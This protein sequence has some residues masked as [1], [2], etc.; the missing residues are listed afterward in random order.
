MT[1]D[2][3]TK[4][5][6]VSDIKFID[7]LNDLVE[8]VP[9][10]KGVKKYSLLLS[11]RSYY[12]VDDDLRTI[13]S[14][15]V[16]D[17]IIEIYFPGKKANTVS[18]QQ[19]KYK[20]K[21]FS[22]LKSSLNKNL[23][24][25]AEKGENP[26]GIIV[27]MSNAF[28]ISMKVELD[29]ASESGEQNLASELQEVLSNAGVELKGDM[30]EK[31]KEVVH[32][33]FISHQKGIE[34]IEEKRAAEK[35]NKQL[36]RK[37]KKLREESSFLKEDIK[38]LRESVSVKEQELE[39]LSK[40]QEVDQGIIKEIEEKIRSTLQ[41]DTEKHMK[42]LTEKDEE[43]AKHEKML[44][45]KENKVLQL[46]REMTEKE[47][48]LRENLKKEKE[49]L[50]NQFREEKKSLQKK[51]DDLVIERMEL[52]KKQNENLDERITMQD[53][54]DEELERLRKEKTEDEKVNQKE[55]KDLTKNM[56]SMMKDE[57][58]FHGER[59]YQRR[60][61]AKKEEN[62]QKMAAEQ[63]LASMEI[64]EAKT[65]LEKEKEEFR[66]E[67]KKKYDEEKEQL[68]K[69]M[70]EEFE[71]FKK[72]QKE[73]KKQK[74]E[75]IQKQKAIREKEKVLLE[76]VQKL[77][78]QRLSKQ[79]AELEKKEERLTQLQKK[80]EKEEKLLLV[81]KS[82]LLNEIK[83]GIGGKTSLLKLKNLV[84]QQEQMLAIKQKI[85]ETEDFAQQGIVE[86]IKNQRKADAEEVQAKKK[87]LRD[88]EIRLE[89]LREQLNQ[90]VENLAEN[91]NKAIDEMK[92]KY[93]NLIA[94]KEK[95]YEEKNLEWNNKITELNSKE[96]ELLKKQQEQ[97][98]KEKELTS[99]MDEK[100]E[101]LFKL[102]DKNI[103]Q[104]EKLIN[105]GKQLTQKA[106]ILEKNYSKNMSQVKAG[107]QQKLQLLEKKSAAVSDMESHLKEEQMVV[108]AKT[109][110]MVE[111]HMEL[112]KPTQEELDKK[113]S[114]LME[115]MT[116]LNQQ[117]DELQK[118]RNE[119]E[120]SREKILEKYKD[121]LE[122]IDGVIHERLQGH[123]EKLMESIRSGVIG[124]AS[125][126]FK[127][128]PTAG[129][130]QEERE[131]MT[132]E[133]TSIKGLEALAGTKAEDAVAKET[134]GGATKK[135][136]EMPSSGEGS[137]GD[138]GDEMELAAPPQFERLLT[139]DYSLSI[140]VPAG[141]FLMGCD[142]IP[143]S[144]PRHKV[145]IERFFRISKYPITIIQFLQFVKE[146]GHFTS[147]EK[148][149]VCGVT[150]GGGDQVKRD[151]N[152]K[153]VE[154][155]VRE[156]VTIDNE[157]ASW[158][159]PFGLE[160]IFEQ[161]FNHPVTMITWWD[162]MAYCDWLS[163][164]AGV[165]CRLPTEKEWEY[166][167][168]NRG[169]LKPGEFYWGHEERVEQHC[170][171]QNSFFGDTTPVDKFLENKT[172]DGVRDMLGNVWEWTLDAYYDYS[173]S[174]DRDDDKQEYKVVRG[175]SYALDKEKINTFI[176]RPYKKMYASSCI[177]FRVVSEE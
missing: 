1:K 111:E 86:E 65:N 34:K 12:K 33:E 19:I 112:S 77:V 172:I 176:R 14:I 8:K 127:G 162:C 141:E 140:T 9:H 2:D 121:K 116:G 139:Q 73:I 85:R 5:E 76:V 35:A 107:Y 133:S 55:W 53:S 60:G 78:N 156:P 16:E 94:R 51:V 49:T 164:K 109:D 87:V 44:A 10:R 115:G 143:E 150:V 50:E 132:R 79:R 147:V 38:E 117:R 24:T 63:I 149:Q 45:E 30:A 21:S 113:E 40:K 119:F 170:N 145:T 3:K 58:E 148:K 128:E 72:E 20:R 66:Q 28:N 83:A 101:E 4:S 95:E 97:L 175:G 23:R 166:V 138:F 47:I 32:N 11:I 27:G 153:V 110:K 154:F 146:T 171:S 168:S 13:T 161:K 26:L 25:M 64:N 160:N 89:K 61:F 124:D 88:E 120:S 152:N 125:E 173:G 36:K 81:E 136:S 167:A 159:Q 96:A 131:G 67:L 92:K 80:L 122:L 100:E 17:L 59:D 74:E 22:S 43:I 158:K 39:D 157:H 177:G 31:L 71:I 62:I 84:K 54:Y 155:I 57:K 118:M 104:K 103:T 174:P 129:L 37:L 165:K 42:A 169:Q 106:A 163:Q 41:V 82:S 142:D 130:P 29:H 56:A 102:I 108:I 48:A 126:I 69:K 68:R 135:A 114:Q 123:V 18:S 93:E 105:T 90:N 52:T 46:Q 91:K 137:V 7:A 6:N 144:D 99:K 151:H 98:G 15:S 75:L 134:S 70:E